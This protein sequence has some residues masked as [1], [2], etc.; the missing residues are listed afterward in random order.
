MSL[1]QTIEQDYKNA[2]KGG[3]KLTIGVLRLLKAALHNAEIEKRGKSGEDRGGLSDEEAVAVIKR[4]VKQLEE[5][6][7]MFAKGGRA[8]L[9]EQNEKEIVIL[10]KYLPQQLSEDTVREAV[11]R[12]IGSMAQAGPSDFGKVMG[13]AMK[14]L[15]GQADGGVVGKIVRELLGE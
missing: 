8:D 3:D 12:V 4:Q 11:K 10:K 7:E 15:K 13:A 1:I 14:E 6:K 2:F 5:A 9:A